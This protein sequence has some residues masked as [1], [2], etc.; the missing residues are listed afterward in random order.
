MDREFKHAITS[1]EDKLLKVWQLDGLKLLSSRYAMTSS[2]LLPDRIDFPQRNAQT[3]DGDQAN[4]G[5]PED[6]GIR[7][8]W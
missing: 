1:G 8:V 2:T 3:A 4:S 7:Q 6:T 5:L